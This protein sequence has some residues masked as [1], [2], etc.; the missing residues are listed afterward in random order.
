MDKNV[1]MPLLAKKGVV[2]VGVGNKI[3]KGMDTGETAYICSV[4]KKLPLDL[5][6]A[7]DLVPPEV[8]GLKTDVV[9]TGRIKA[10]ADP[11]KKHR[12]APAGVSVGHYKIT[13]GTLGAWVLD[14]ENPLAGWHILSNNHVLANVN[15]AIE[16]DRILQPGPHDGGSVSEDQIAVLK[17]FVPLVFT[18]DPPN[19]KIAIAVEKLINYLP[20]RLCRRHRV[21]SYAR[22]DETNTVDC[23]LAAP[24]TQTDVDLSINDI[25]FHTGRTV[26]SILGMQVQKSGRT[27]GVTTGK[28]VQIEVAAIVDMG[29]G[30]KALFTDQIVADNSMSAGG[31]SGSLVL[32]MDKKITGLLFAGSDKI[33]VYNRIHNVIEQ[34]NIRFWD[35]H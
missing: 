28:V 8:F 35:T 20:E 25:G 18:E 32:D 31:D 14:S 34:L 11:T 17:R 13:A 21:K 27:T 10:L 24:L 9:E 1:Y 16:G 23:A 7:K 26:H 29:N 4:E 22:T 6:R 19:C 2:A 5:I 12:P 15:E 30:K 33:T 3:S